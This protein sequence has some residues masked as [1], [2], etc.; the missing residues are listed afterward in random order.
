VTV[1]LL[2]SGSNVDSS[3]SPLRFA[4]PNGIVIYVTRGLDGQRLGDLASTAVA[5]LDRDRAVGA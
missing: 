3:R 2:I 1:R 4:L 5:V